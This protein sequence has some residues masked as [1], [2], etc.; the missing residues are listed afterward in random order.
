MYLSK[1][2]ARSTQRSLS[3]PTMRV[4]TPSS[5]N[6]AGIG[7]GTSGVSIYISSPSSGKNNMLTAP[8]N[9]RPPFT[10]S[11]ASWW[12]CSVSSVITVSL[13]VSGLGLSLNLMNLAAL[14]SGSVPGGGISLGDTGIPGAEFYEV[15]SLLRLTGDGGEGESGGSRREKGKGKGIEPIE[16]VDDD[17]I[18]ED[19]AEAG[20]DRGGDGGEEG[21]ASTKVGKRR[22]ADTEEGAAHVAASEGA[23]AP[24]PSDSKE[25]APA[26]WI[27]DPR[28]EIPVLQ[29]VLDRAKSSAGSCESFP[30][31]EGAE[32]RLLPVVL[33][34]SEVGMLPEFGAIE[35]LSSWLS[36]SEARER[37][38]IRREKGG[39]GGSA[40]EEEKWEGEGGR[41]PICR[42]PPPT[43]CHVT[44]YTIVLMSH[45]TDRLKDLVNHLRELLTRPSASEVVLVWN[46]LKS[47]LEGH[48]TGKYLLMWHSDPSHPFRFFFALD[49]GGLNND[50]LN[51]YHPKIRP[52][53]EAIMYFDDD[54]PFFS[55]MAM[56]G[57][58]FELWRRNSDA[59]VGCFPRNI[60]MRGDRMEGAQYE[61]TERSI[62]AARAGMATRGY[63]ALIATGGGGAPQQQREGAVAP[64]FTPTCRDRTRDH[65]EYNYHLFSEYAGHMLLPSGSILHRNYLCFIWHPAFKELRD[66]VRR[67]PTHCDD[68]TVSTVVSQLSGRA[69]AVF[70]RRVRANKDDPDLA[71]IAA[72]ATERGEEKEKE[73]AAAAAPAPDKADSNHRRLLWQQN[74][75]GPMREEAINSVNGYFGSVNPGSVGWCAHGKTGFEKKKKKKKKNK[76]YCDP[77]FPELRRIPW[78]N[79][80]GVGY[81][82]CLSPPPK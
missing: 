78:A 19:Y 33:N 47:E 39:A 70:P 48:D 58:G 65:L 46:A 77:E 73:L 43:S 41:Y 63:N 72:A 20:G 1:M 80:G 40:G 74:N 68:Q 53:E 6:A 11:L 18:S 21:A 38:S 7:R 71:D 14:T 60:R 69:P 27:D 75:W 56:E 76:Y 29:S 34:A 50:L 26:E 42:L 35:S 17:G 55:E 64:R 10:S 4:S 13:L 2:E 37:S 49:E 79:E 51:R 24:P 16:I 61:A 67:H 59:Q 62:K 23:I 81:D 22:G 54:G 30:A 5:G 44:N 36:G 32:K 25:L 8:K 9:N 15:R 28:H 45:T 12:G 52:R 57:A 31:P 66:Y 82:V 3:Q